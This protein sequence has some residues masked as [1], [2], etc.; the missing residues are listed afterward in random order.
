MAKN[1]VMG[2]M[3]AASGFDKNHSRKDKAAKK[4]KAFDWRVITGDDLHE[5]DY[6]RHEQLLSVM[7]ANYDGMVQ[8]EDVHSLEFL[9]NL[10]VLMRRDYF[11]LNLQTMFC[12]Y[13]SLYEFPYVQQSL[14]EG[15]WKKHQKEVALLDKHKF[16]FLYSITQTR[17]MRSHVLQA[18][19]VI[20]LP[21]VF[22][23][24]NIDR[25]LRECKLIVEQQASSSTS[26]LS[27]CKKA[28]VFVIDTIFTHFFE[29]MLRGECWKSMRA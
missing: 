20:C 28:E 6:S 2:A 12:L 27:V 13:G 14:L 17:T 5:S 18:D 24:S 21:R 1:N 15:W 10:C 8:N 29:W 23:E 26:F 25:W 22:F 4:T 3:K 7:N 11:Y 16:P 9:D 19:N